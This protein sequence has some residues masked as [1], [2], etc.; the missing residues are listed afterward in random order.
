[1]KLTDLHESMPRTLYHGTTLDVARDPSVQRWG[2]EP[3]VGDFVQDAYG[4]GG[5]ADARE[6]GYY[7]LVFAADK[8]ELGKALNAIV[9][10]VATKLGK[11]TITPQEF[12]NHG[13][14]VVLKHAEDDFKH[15]DPDDYDNEDGGGGVESGDY[16]TDRRQQGDFILTGSKL[17]RVLERLGL[18][19]YSHGQIDWPE[20]VHD[21]GF[22]N[23]RHGGH[24]KFKKVAPVASENP[25][26]VP[27]KRKVAESLTEEVRVAT[28]FWFNVRTKQFVPW[29]VR[30]SNVD[31]GGPHHDE[32]LMADPA[33]FGLDYREGKTGADYSVEAAEDGWVRGVIKSRGDLY[34]DSNNKVEAQATL[35]YLISRKLIDRRTIDNLLV[36][37][38]DVGSMLYR[39]PGEISQFLSESD[40]NP[41]I[42]KFWYHARSGK[43]EQWHPFLNDTADIYAEPH[44]EQKLFAEPD[45]YGIKAPEGVDL[46]DLMDEERYRQ[47]YENGWTRGSIVGSK[48]MIDAPTMLDAQATIRAL[49]NKRM[50]D[51]RETERVNIGIQGEFHKGITLDGY[52]ALT[53]FLRSGINEGQLNEVHYQDMF[54]ERFEAFHRKYRN[55]VRKKEINPEHYYVQFRNFRNDKLDRSAYD[56][57]NHTD[58][59]GVY[60]YPLKYVLRHPADIWYGAAARYVRVLQNTARNPLRLKELNNLG[61]GR[62]RNMLW[63]MGLNVSDK[64]LR[65]IKRNYQWTG[66]YAPVNTFMRAFQINHEG[67]TTE[68]GWGT[69]KWPMRSAKEQTQLLLKAGYDAVIDEGTGAINEREPEQIIFLTRASFKVIETYDLRPGRGEADHMTINQPGHNREFIRKFARKI[70]NALDD[71]LTDK[72]ETSNLMGWAY[73]W[74]KAGRRIEIQ[75]ERPNNYYNQRPAMEKPHKYDR[76][77]TNHVIEVNVRTEVGDIEVKEYSGSARLDQIVSDIVRRFERLK[78]EQKQTYWSPEDR[79][80]FLKKRA[81]EQHEAIGN[82]M[83][84]EHDMPPIRY[85]EMKAMEQQGLNVYGIPFTKA[86]MLHWKELWKSHNMNQQVQGLP[87][88]PLKQFIAQQEAEHESLKQVVESADLPQQYSFHNDVTGHHHGQTDGTIYFYDRST[89]GDLWPPRRVAGRLNWTQYQGKIFIN[90]IQV[91]P[92]FQRRGIG[93][94]LVKE[95]QK[96]FPQEKLVWTNTTPEG[97][98][99][100][101]SLS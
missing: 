76:K 45:K 48:L 89:A 66:K 35:R 39:S 37:M 94:A 97:T 74:T 4:L 50:I 31:S 24:T 36:D 18:W 3:R 14:L 40:I 59:M 99:L 96:E 91:E 95:L 46:G 26:F 29:T 42:T 86:R 73:L 63:R 11:R 87:K 64:D 23:P 90:Y 100:R 20:Q 27:F 21:E 32:A 54:P 9:H 83:R 13:A 41:N 49:M 60:G 1:M 62:V 61:W 16:Y 93:T 12:L 2:L 19:P 82:R 92:E 57:P 7:P 78:G 34:L 80:M 10:H 8:P 84:A 69:K 70:A 65:W 15:R 72:T 81:E 30:F 43:L 68:D 25:L 52:A 17:K 71:K 79:A 101:K 38:A 6:M 75:I 22:P 98:A 47:A 58:P 5:E 77:H 67:E 51:P 56:K 88:M 33:K 85:A 44:H 28:K 55:M 53:K